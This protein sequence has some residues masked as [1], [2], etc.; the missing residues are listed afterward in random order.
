MNVALDALWVR[1]MRTATS[2]RTLGTAL[3]DHHSTPKPT[4]GLCEELRAVLV[5]LHALRCD[6]R[7]NCAIALP[8]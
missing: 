1:P 5:S 6:T 2:P 3:A 8:S 7:R 4:S